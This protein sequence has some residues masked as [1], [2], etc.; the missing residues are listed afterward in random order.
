[1]SMTKRELYE[2]KRR[3]ASEAGRILREWQEERPFLNKQANLEE[4][5]Q[6]D[7]DLDDEPE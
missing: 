7:L 5:G 2:H 1:M 6:G 4:A 3:K